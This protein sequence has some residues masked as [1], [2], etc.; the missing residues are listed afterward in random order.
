MVAKV[1]PAQ[2]CR[3]TNILVAQ[4]RGEQLFL[5]PFTLGKHP[6]LVIA[7]TG[8]HQFVMH[9]LVFGKSSDD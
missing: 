4:D 2:L 5:D 3:G 1:R 6:R 8:G 7:R 9:V